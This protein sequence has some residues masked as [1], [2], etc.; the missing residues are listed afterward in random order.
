MDRETFYQ[1]I[2]EFLRTQSPDKEIDPIGEHDNLFD[3]GLLDS[4]N[5]IY[6]ILFIEELS[7]KE[8]QLERYSPH[9]FHT[10]Q[11]I[12]DEVVATA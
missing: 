12:F 8:I 2:K 10:I 6:L 1:S 11:R 3:A 4:F 5:M 7:Q 9:H